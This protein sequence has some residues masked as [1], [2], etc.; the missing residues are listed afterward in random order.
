[1]KR[2]ILFIFLL[3]GLQASA[4]QTF[5]PNNAPPGTSPNTLTVRTSGLPSDSLRRLWFILNGTSNEALLKTDFLRNYYYGSLGNTNYGLF[6]NSANNKMVQANGFY[7]SNVGT[8][9]IVNTYQFNQEGLAYFNNGSTEML[10]DGASMSGN[11]GRIV[12]G[13]GVPYIEAYAK[14]P[15]LFKSGNGT[16]GI[17]AR[18]DSLYNSTGARFVTTSGTNGDVNLGSYSFIS[19][20]TNKIANLSS[21]GLVV[22]KNTSNENYLQFNNSITD[23]YL[24]AS[25]NNIGIQDGGGNRFTRLQQ[26]KILNKNLSG[27]FYTEVSFEDATA[28]R[29]I[30]F[31]NKTGKVVLDV[32]LANRPDSTTISNTYVHRINNINENIN[33]VKT[34]NP[35]LTS[36]V[37]NQENYGT[38]IRPVRSSGAFVNTQNVPLLI[39]ANATL[40]PIGTNM[41]A[42]SILQ[43]FNGAEGVRS[44]VLID[45]YNS[46]GNNG[47]PTVALRT[48]RQS[49]ATFSAVQSGDILG[50]FQVGGYA[51]TDW[52]GN[53]PTLRA[54]ASET[55]SSTSQGVR[56]RMFVKPNGTT[57]TFLEALRLENDGSVQVGNSTLTKA[58]FS[59]N[60]PS[61]GLGLVT[62]TA[63]GTTVTGDANTQFLNTFNPGDAITIG[64]ETK[65]ISAIASNSS[66]TVETTFTN[67]NTNSAYTVN[68]VGTKFMVNGSGNVTIQNPTAANSG[69]QQ[70][71]PY[72]T[73]IGNGYG[74][75]AG[76]SQPLGFRM[77]VQP[78]Q[79]T[80]VTGMLTWQRSQNN[81]T[82]D[83]V[84]QLT[85]GGSLT[86][87]TGSISTF[88]TTSGANSTDGMVM[89]NVTAA[90]SGTP[91]WS[92]R[93]RWTG[94]AY[95]TGAGASRT[96]DAIAELKT[97]SAAT[98]TARWAL[99]MQSNAGGYNERWSIDHLGLEYLNGT[100]G[101]A[102]QIP[103]VNAAGTSM[104]WKTLT[105]GNGISISPATGSYT[106][107]ATG[108]PGVEITGTTQTAAVNTIYIPHN[109][110]MTTITLPSTAA[111]FS[112]VQVIGEGAGRY[113]LQHGNS[114][115]VIVGVGGFTTVAG[116]THGVEANDQN[117]TI[118]LRKTAANK[119]TFSSSQGTFSAY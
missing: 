100:A 54:D 119:W 30:T 45:G 56:T 91:Q 118:T 63:G 106:I 116:T 5:Y 14:Q 46:G 102:N 18:N 69:V 13:G 70:P 92:R 108:N 17:F 109:A 97:F 82:Y 58:Q 75:T 38:I 26:G 43:R 60:Q 34:F 117:G 10:L 57:G 87:N 36:T 52:G 48:A 2:L 51:G 98:P 4:Q 39:D 86:I 24:L 83:P 77:I 59:V 96:M 85:A 71:S 104:E 107:S 21:V 16:G 29:F 112:V 99:S 20:S 28:N 68:S 50:Q 19:Q 66:M 44:T 62:N 103:G 6:R 105:A 111:I 93:T 9:K 53:N 81:G 3:T 115:D 114:S 78:A 47:Y 32:D 80:T 12:F 25:P 110:A 23:E 64:A 61:T 35:T 95:D 88:G 101:S 49:G 22:T 27:G 31:P 76:T 89:N 37:D 40:A 90:I 41:T 33:G 11:L 84:M 67:A 7:F 8:Q 65:R 113:R 73:M 1:M 42:N 72:F 94:Q 55:W 15:F 74:T 79:A